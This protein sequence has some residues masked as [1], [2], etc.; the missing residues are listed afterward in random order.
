MHGDAGQDTDVAGLKASLA[1]AA[2][3]EEKTEKLVA[4]LQA[5]AGEVS[6]LVRD[7]MAAMMRA[8]QARAQAQ[9]R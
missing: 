3:G 2:G 1:L 6:E 7:G 8:A 9:A 4:A 5:H